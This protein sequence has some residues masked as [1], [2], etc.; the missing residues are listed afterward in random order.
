PV[1]PDSQASIRSGMLLQIDIIP[2]RAGYA[3]ASIEDTVAVADEALR[4]ELAENW[5]A[6][7]QRIVTRRAYIRQQL[8][9]VLP[10]EVL[11]FSNTV[12]YL[13]PWLLD[14]QR[15]LVCSAG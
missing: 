5:P 14:K 1:G 3:G 8:G 12:G 2:S 15:A 4:E 11:P 6:L 7:W 10:E 9:I 13:R